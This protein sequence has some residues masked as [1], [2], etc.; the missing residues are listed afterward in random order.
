MKSYDEVKERADK[1]LCKTYA[2]YPVAVK[3]ARGSR[4]WDF[5]GKEYIDLLSG[6][7]VTSIGHC[8]PDVAD[9]V[10][11][12][13]KKLVHVSNLFYQEEQ[14]LLAEKLVQTA[15][16]HKVFL[17]NSGAEANEAAI[18]LAR[19]YQQKVKNKNAYRV[20][21][22]DHC[23]HGRTLATVAATGQSRFQDGFLPMPDGFDHIEWGRLDVLE[24]AIRPETA[25]VLFEVIQG[26]GG[27]RPVTREFADGVAA[28][29]KKHGLVLIVDEVQTGLCRTGKWWGFDHYGLKPD[30][31]TSA[32]ALANGIPMGAMLATEEVAAGFDY[33]S[34][35]TTFGGNAL[36]SAAALATLEVMDRDKLAENAAGLGAWARSRF[37]AVGKARPGCIKEVRGMGLLIGIDLTFPGKEVWLKLLERGFILNL[38]QDTV[39]R[40]V[41][42][43]NIPMEDLEAFAVALEEV[44][45]EVGN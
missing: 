14:V 31:F 42:A 6:I 17:C 16:G 24:E 34:H 11:R 13:A 27:V 10:C 28:L 33:G 4:I 45:G 12:Q 43:L 44:L 22:F 41:P 21:T 8:H 5:D 30:I 36:V 23:F 39:L 7:A 38:T 35:A 9:A 2:R 40:L 19:R 26:E 1:V 18:K 25:A 32:K 20:I 37:E 3:S 15:P 29:C